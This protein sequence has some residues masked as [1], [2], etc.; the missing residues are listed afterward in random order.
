MIDW[1][2]PI[3]TASM[4]SFHTTRV[5]PSRPRVTLR[6]RNFPY[7]KKMMSIHQLIWSQL[8]RR[9]YPFIDCISLYI[10]RIRWKRRVQWQIPPFIIFHAH[11][12]YLAFSEGD[13]ERWDPPS[14][15]PA[16][17]SLS[18]PLIGS[19]A[20]SC[21]RTSCRL[22][23]PRSRRQQVKQSARPPYQQSS[24][25]DIISSII[26]APAAAGK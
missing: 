13:L 3:W 23:N 24:S 4:L 21:C 5:C 12:H 14:F 1:T 17:L 8:Y 7:K 20:A 25:P 6:T 16:A 10:H 11:T 19:F 22:L 2:L 18:Y 9:A 15:T 26:S